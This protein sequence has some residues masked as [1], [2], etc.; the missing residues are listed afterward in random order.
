MRS[1]TQRRRSDDQE[2]RPTEP[3]P[4]LPAELVDWAARFRVELLAAAERQV[5][6]G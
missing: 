5:A 1:V 6:R 3:D 2:H 4:V